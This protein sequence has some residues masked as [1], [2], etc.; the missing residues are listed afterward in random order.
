MK[1]LNQ[2][3]DMIVN[4]DNAYAVAI[5]SLEDNKGIR[6]ALGEHGSIIL[7]RYKTEDRT[8]EVLLDI[9]EKMKSDN[10]DFTYEM[11]QE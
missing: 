11:P 10:F 7:G 8:K 3:K 9:Y 6:V 5:S 1:I 2:D 4:L